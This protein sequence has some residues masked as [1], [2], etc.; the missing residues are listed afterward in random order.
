MVG[1]R[2]AEKTAVESR[3]EQDSDSPSMGTNPGDVLVGKYRIERIL[4][5][6]AMGVV[7][8]AT[9]LTLGGLVAVKVLS[10]R[11]THRRGIARLQRE[12]RAT[13]LIRSEH[14]ARVMD[15]GTI[16]QDKP[17]LV[18]EYL[19]GMDVATALRNRGPFSIVE[20][21]NVVI[22]ACDALAAA[23]VLGIV[24]RD[25]KPSNLYLAHQLDGSSRLKV[26]DFGLS[27]MPEELA[28]GRLTSATAVMGSP[29]YM[30]PEQIANP[31]DV[32][33]RADIW[34]LGVI[35]YE[36]VTGRKPFDDSSTAEIFTRIS[37]DRP[38]PP[39]NWRRD[40]PSS[41]E[42][43][44]LECLEKNPHNRPAD[45]GMIAEK[46]APFGS[47]AA[48]LLST[49]IRRVIGN[50]GTK[51]ESPVETRELVPS[52]A[53][54]D[55]S[56][57]RIGTRAEWQTESIEENIPKVGVR[58]GMVLGGRFRI[59]KLLGRGAM[60]AVYQVADQQG[61]PFAVK[62]LPAEAS[63]DPEARKRLLREARLAST[64][65]HAH[66]VRVMDV[67]LDDRDD[68]PFIVMEL[69]EGKNLAEALQLHGALSPKAAAKIFRQVC[70]GLAAAHAHGLVHRDVKPANIFLH[71]STEGAIKVKLCDFGIAKRTESNTLDASAQALTKTGFMLGTPAY[72]SPE[73][74]KDAT[75][76][77]TRSDIW[78]VCVS[79]YE[80]LSGKHPWPHC[81]TLG[82]LIVA[83]CTEKPVP[84][85]KAAAWVEP[86]L[87][88]IIMR[89][90]EVDPQKRW[91]AARKLE[92]ALARF[93]DGGDGLTLDDIVGIPPDERVAHNDSYASGSRRKLSPR[94]FIAVALAGVLLGGVAMFSPAE[95]PLTAKSHFPGFV[96]MVEPS[97]VKEV[98]PMDPSPSLPISSAEPIKSAALSPAPPG[99][100][101]FREPGREKKPD[102]SRGVTTPEF[103]SSESPPLVAPKPSSTPEMHL[104]D[105]F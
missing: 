65:T 96:S 42:A 39:S 50:I 21:V 48:Q 72:A 12:A 88:A 17:F 75:A 102:V 41:I 86:S 78:S 76:V 95:Q 8:S 89:G 14:V 13:A 25:L 40:L 73:Q 54:A 18:M 93:V 9:H 51:E 45:V 105:D 84:L 43:L 23:H 57:E 69:L 19:E 103:V 33:A 3:E 79:M 97:A 35:L 49:R 1:T 44:I 22:E 77:D 104:Q 37:T 38:K 83:I 52:G 92:S 32:D 74:I 29:H 71:E 46:L 16:D 63:M 47:A 6:G 36:L 5:Q 67:C 101:R 28:D 11:A 27:K 60:G 100:T 4:G 82:E 61:A 98:E 94:V 59:E 20:A 10:P 66:V 15:V 56:T 68:T 30:A 58:A 80:A 62:L 91:P 7:F 64:L 90:L 99:T 2:S 24:H 55:D 85:E 31:R 87:S 81:R 26:V 34:S 53:T 70:Q